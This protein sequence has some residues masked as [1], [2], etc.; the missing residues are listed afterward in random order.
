MFKY[1]IYTERLKMDWLKS[2]IAEN[3]PG[4]TVYYTD[5]RW[6]LIDE[7]SVMIEI[8]TNNPAAEHWLQLIA[9]K[10]KGYNRQDSVLITKSNLEV[11]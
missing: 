4:F 3:F 5:G 10:I 11:L 1:N 7:K 2:I 8:I 6:G 9:L